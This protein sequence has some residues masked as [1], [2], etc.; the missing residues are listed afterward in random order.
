MDKELISISEIARD[1]NKRRQTVHKIVRRLGLDIVKRK[2]DGSR[3]QQVSCI[4]LNDYRELKR[5]LDNQDDS[6]INSN[7]DGEIIG[8]VFY[9]ISLEP[10]LDPGRMK[11]GF[12]TN[13]NERLRSHRTSAPFAEV[14]DT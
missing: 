9:V 8:G 2:G 4:S 6:P 5:H 10:E 7:N 3:G 13:I 11:V 12:T 14:V 1:H